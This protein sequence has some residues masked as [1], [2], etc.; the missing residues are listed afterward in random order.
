MEKYGEPETQRGGEFE[1]ANG[2][3]IWTCEYRTAGLD[4]EVCDNQDNKEAYIRGIRACG[5]TKAKTKRG[6]GIGS[7]RNKAKAA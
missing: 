7:T 4:F 2:C 5:I 3:G 6:I 1:P